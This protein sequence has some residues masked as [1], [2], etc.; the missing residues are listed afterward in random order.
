MFFRILTNQIKTR[1]FSSDV[2]DRGY[3][4][5]IS[6]RMKS[7]EQQTGT[8]FDPDTP[9]MIRL[10]GHKFST[11]T[12][13]FSKPY[14]P[15]IHLAMM[16]TTAAVMKHFTPCTV[17]TCSDEITLCFEP[18]SSMADDQPSALPYSAKVQK[19]TTLTAGCASAAFTRYFHDHFPSDTAPFAFFDARGFNVPS[20]QEAW[21]NIRWRLSDAQR[22][23]RSALGQYFLPRNQV[24]KTSSYELARIVNETYGIDYYTDLPPWYRSGTLLKTCQRQHV[25]FNP[26][27]NKPTQVV[28]NFLGFCDFE[29]F[30]Q[31]YKSLS[32]A[33]WPQLL[34]DNLTLDQGDH[35]FQSL[36][37]YLERSNQFPP[38]QFLS[39]HS[40][41]SIKK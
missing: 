2:K 15:R 24:F 31:F 39:K 20:W 37:E 8:H 6:A 30:D 23:S 11:L 34:H 28:R 38:I 36:E 25:G 9:F 7:Y 18:R 29:S 35:P 13:S 21:L 12:R 40:S 5:E 32:V 27:D 26:K 19:L 22:N 4:N 14:D 10:D 16:H 1:R 3:W 33:T 41:K 17:Y